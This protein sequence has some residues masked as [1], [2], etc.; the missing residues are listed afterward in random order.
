MKFI[1]T[2]NDRSERCV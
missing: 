1:Q 2:E